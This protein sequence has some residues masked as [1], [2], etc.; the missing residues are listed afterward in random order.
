MKK[1]DVPGSEAR[2]V[3]TCMSGFAHQDLGV[4][5]EIEIKSVSAELR[6]SLRMM[7]IGWLDFRRWYLF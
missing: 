4:E 5:L 1:F 6:H 7:S 3:H 2:A